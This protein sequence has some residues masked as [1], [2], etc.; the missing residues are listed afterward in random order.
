[1]NKLQEHEIQCN[2]DLATLLVSDKIVPKLL[3]V[4]KFSVAKSRLNCNQIATKF[5]S[6]GGLVTIVG[7]IC[8]DVIKFEILTFLKFC[9]GLN[10]EIFL[11]DAVLASKLFE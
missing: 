3:V 4:I 1:M 10:G 2:L 5:Y 6:Q 9:K 8:I 7:T 11:E